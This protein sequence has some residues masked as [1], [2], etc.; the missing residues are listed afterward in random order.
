MTFGGGSMQQPKVFLP[1]GFGWSDWASV[2]NMGTPQVLGRTLGRPNFSFSTSGSHC[3]NGEVRMCLDFSVG[4]DE[5][6]SSRCLF[7]WLRLLTEGIVIKTLYPSE[8]LSEVIKDRIHSPY[9]QPPQ[10]SN[11]CMSLTYC[12]QLDLP[13]LQVTCVHNGRLSIT[14]H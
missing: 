1:I 10:Y 6:A 4:M 14:T 13:S 7:F 9:W 11:L 2:Q 12:L 8:G 3:P 5:G